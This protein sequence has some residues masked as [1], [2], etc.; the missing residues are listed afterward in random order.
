M[1]RIGTGVL[2][3]SAFSGNTKAKIV[4][5]ALKKFSEGSFNVKVIYVFTL[6]LKSIYVI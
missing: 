2:V 5:D 3:L 6:Q 1:L 4:T